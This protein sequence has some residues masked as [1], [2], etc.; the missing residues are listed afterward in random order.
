MTTTT[1]QTTVRQGD[2]TIYARLM[3]LDTMAADLDCPL[4]M[5]A[6]PETLAVSYEVR[7]C[8]ERSLASRAAWSV[9]LTKLYPLGAGIRT[10]HRVDAKGKWVIKA[11]IGTRYIGRY[12]EETAKGTIVGWYDYMRG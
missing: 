12:N 9:A 8:P 3:A 7:G 5:V 1:A 6:T 11:Y 10:V 4:T 2:A